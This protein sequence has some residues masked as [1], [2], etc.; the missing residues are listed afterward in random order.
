MAAPLAGTV[1]LDVDGRRSAFLEVLGARVVGTG[2]EL[3][4]DLAA[5]ADVAVGA[6]LDA[7][8]LLAANERLVVVSVAGD[9]PA[10]LLAARAG[11][12]QATGYADGPP[13][14]PG[15]P[16]GAA[17]GMFV[18]LAALA[19]LLR[20]ERTGRGLVVDLSAP[21]SIALLA[22]QA[23]ER[24]GNEDAIM[25]PHGLFRCR[26]GEPWL[27]VAVE[28]DDEW[29]GLASAIGRPELADEPG[30]GDGLAR[31]ERRA[32]LEELLAEW[33]A[34]RGAEDA[35]SELRAAG[36]PAAPS[37][38]AAASGAA[39]SRLTV[40]P[41]RPAARRRSEPPRRGPG[42][43]AGLRV[44]EVGTDRAA[45]YCARL[46]ARFGADV[47]KVE[48]PP[49]GDPL[50]RRGPFPPG[51][52]DR[53]SGALFAA[54]N[55]GKR[56]VTLDVATPTGAGLLGRL[57]EDADVLVEDLSRPEAERVGLR[58][59]LL[60][61]RF[62]RLI[63]VPVTVF[64]R[65][66]PY[67]GRVGRSLTAAAVG[68]VSVGIGSP[69]R[70]PLAPPY[71]L[72]AFQAGLAAAAGAVVALLARRRTGDGQQVDTAEMQVWATLHT[73][74]S[75]LTY[76]YLG[77]SGLRQGNRGIGLYPNVFLP[78]K[79]GFVCLTC[80]PLHHWVAFLECMGTP[81][82]T[83]EPRYRNR[84]AML[85]EYPEEVDALL[86]DWLRAHTRAELFE[87]AREKRFPLAPGLTVD[88][89]L[90]SEHLAARGFWDELE[91]D[92]DR[93]RVP[94]SPARFSTIEPLE[95]SRAPRLGEHTAAVLGDELG[96]AAATLT[97][98]RQ[99]G[100]A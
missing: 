97:R 76:L 20:R 21:G 100:I 99:A 82:W 88:E 45:P 29:R 39:P 9:G 90:A 38:A 92:G 57:L 47:V 44:V 5:T 96:L 61:E 91:L 37:A 19:G 75:I 54:L 10:P 63:H 69:G 24:T 12:S 32:E 62:P 13:A 30:L 80:T 87:L 68:G 28:S 46:L 86:V 98:L 64:G 83:L 51:R 26:P 56:S 81:A 31:W 70:R 59:D 95:H 48:R 6:T 72:G 66:G 34:P 43:L 55:V 36:V 73:G 94:G 27:A 23:Q 65:S 79:D 4:P 14:E 58:D 84:R 8:A 71:S 35:A 25:A 16:V 22:G 1:V 11:L 17:V 78:A 93:L 77:V 89:T 3:A 15:G 67:A 42:P 2:A 40:E 53:E 18:A 85:E 33:A 41:P 49:N 60:A 50:R 7:D 52:L 74:A